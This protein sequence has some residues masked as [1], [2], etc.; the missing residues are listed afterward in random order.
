MIQILKIIT[1]YSLGLFY[2]VV[3]IKHFTNLDFF[4]V[5]VPPYIPFPEFMVY[6]S[7]LFEIILGFFLIIK[8]TR[9]YGALG[10]VILLIAVFPANI[11]LCRSDVALSIYKITRQQALIRLPFQLPLIIIAYWHSIKESSKKFDLICI[12]LFIPTFIYFLKLSL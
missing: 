4:L 3:G 10:L 7:G 1:I 12:L 9:R 2:I 11:Y 6:I 5:I 8:K